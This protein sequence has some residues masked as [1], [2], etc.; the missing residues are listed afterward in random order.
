VGRSS[1][2]ISTEAGTGRDDAANF[3][4]KPEAAPEPVGRYLVRGHAPAEGG[5]GK[6]RYYIESPTLFLMVMMI[7]PI[8]RGVGLLLRD[9][10]LGR[11]VCQDRPFV[12]M[13]HR[14]I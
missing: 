10:N 7:W 8:F 1:R 12:L 9:E 13:A 14:C 6:R 3:G 11:A 5:N 2:T 4:P